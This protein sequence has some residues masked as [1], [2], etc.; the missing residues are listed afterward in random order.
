MLTR[1]PWDKK[2]CEDFIQRTN[3]DKIPIRNLR[4]KYYEKER[5]PELAKC[6]IYLLLL[7]EPDIN[8]VYLAFHKKKTF[9]STK[10]PTFIIW[11]YHNV[12]LS[13]EKILMSQPGRHLHKWL[14][15]LEDPWLFLVNQGL[16]MSCDPLEPVNIILMKK[17]KT[18]SWQKCW[19]IILFWL[20]SH[21]S[22]PLGSPW[23]WGHRLRKRRRIRTGF[24]E[25]QMFYI[26]LMRISESFWT[27][28]NSG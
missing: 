15:S 7:E 27:S 2:S 20:L 5:E 10:Y 28:S 14:R 12:F 21:L 1:L 24:L 3:N 4:M 18:R 11:L 25:S 16:S 13:W 8:G 9:K 23:G 17:R 19:T 6:L 26:L 22:C